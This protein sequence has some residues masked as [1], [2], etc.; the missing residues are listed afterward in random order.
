MIR[1]EKYPQALAAL[2]QVIVRARFMAVQAEHSAKV[3]DLL[4]AAEY[5]PQLIAEAEDRTE[6]FAAALKELSE[7]FPYCGH[8]FTEFSREPAPRPTALAAQ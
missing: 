6:T 1:A 4:D 2:Q 5:L 8:I 7:R 3:V